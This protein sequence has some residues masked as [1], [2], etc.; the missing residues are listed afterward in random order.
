VL[1]TGLWKQLSKIVLDD[2]RVPNGYVACKRSAY[3]P[4]TIGGCVGQNFRCR[5][6]V[7]KLGQNDLVA[8]VRGFQIGDNL[9]VLC[10]IVGEFGFDRQLHSG[11]RSSDW[12]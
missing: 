11:S 9:G 8:C 4:V 2:R 5:L 7:E 6:N 3:S 10:K 12:N 1:Q